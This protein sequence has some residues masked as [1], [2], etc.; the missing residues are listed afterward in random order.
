MERLR[1]REAEREAELAARSEMREHRLRMAAE[2]SKNMEERRQRRTR[3]QIVKKFLKSA[4]LQMTALE[5]VEKDTELKTLRE[6]KR[7]VPHACHMDGS[8]RAGLGNMRERGGKW[9]VLCVSSSS[10]KNHPPP[11]SPSSV[12]TG[13]SCVCGSPPLFPLYHIHSHTPASV[14]HGRME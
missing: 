1:Q 2:I 4:A 13:I 6:Q 10:M 12:T 8:G 14:A 7:K 5:D 9:E 11:L 3:R